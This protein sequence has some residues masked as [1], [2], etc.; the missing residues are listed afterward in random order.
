[1][2]KTEKIFW[3][4]IRN[5]KIG[6]KF[7]RQM[8]LVIGRYNFIPDFYSA[9]KKLIIEIDGGIHDLPENKEYDSLKD[10]ILIEAGYKVLRFKN[11]EILNNLESVIKII[12]TTPHPRPLS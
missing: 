4:E 10:E 2:T 3:N 5:Q 7:R 11:E 8:P 1:M 12:K 9:D 6:I